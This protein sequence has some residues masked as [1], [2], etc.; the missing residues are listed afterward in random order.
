[1]IMTNIGKNIA[2]LILSYII[3]YNKLI[4]TLQNYNLVFW[5][6]QYKNISNVLVQYSHI[7]ES[8]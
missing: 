4:R 2:P 3:S 7:M 6:K 5:I 1:M 8:I